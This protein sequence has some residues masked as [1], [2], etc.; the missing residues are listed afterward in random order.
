MTFRAN[1]AKVR[2]HEN[3]RD[4]L[5]S[6]HIDAEERARS[7]E[8]FSALVARY[9]PVVESY[10]TWH[11]LVTNTPDDRGSVTEPST[12]CGYQGLDHTVSF[13]NAFV[14]C[15]YEN[16]QAVIDSVQ[17]LRA[18]G[19]LPLSRRHWTPSST[20]RP[21]RQSWSCASGPADRVRRTGHCPKQWRSR[22]CWRR[23][24]RVG[25]GP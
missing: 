12:E 21:Q 6:R 16:A 9:G 10:P 3:A 20:M 18:A 25:G 5:V 1:E 22:S 4:Y 19:T 2:G 23:N 7:L 24:C 11:P 13:A 14:T 8:A 17:R 15:P